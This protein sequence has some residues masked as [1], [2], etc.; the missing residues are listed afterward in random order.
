MDLVIISPE[1]KVMKSSSK[2]ETLRKK[3]TIYAKAV[4][5]P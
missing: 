1:P 3:L 4:I 5:L 2:K